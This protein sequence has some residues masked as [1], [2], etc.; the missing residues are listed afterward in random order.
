MWKDTVFG[1][2]RLTEEEMQRCPGMRYR[3]TLVDFPPLAYKR[4]TFCEFLFDFLYKK[5]L[6]KWGVI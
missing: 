4:D 3:Y 6:P 2:R 5:S 1:Y